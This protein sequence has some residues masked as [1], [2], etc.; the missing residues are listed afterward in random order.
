MSKDKA[1]VVIIDEPFD[2]P[3]VELVENNPANPVE[4][5]NTW[6]D[7]LFGPAAQRIQERLDAKMN[8][9]TP[10]PKASEF[11]KKLAAANEADSDDI[12]FPQVDEA[13]A[14]ASREKTIEEF[15]KFMDEANVERKMVVMPQPPHTAGL[16]LLERSEYL[17]S[18]AI[19]RMQQQLNMV[20]D[21][22][23]CHFVLLEVGVKAV[24][25]IPPSPYC[26]EMIV[27]NVHERVY[28][29][30]AAEMQAYL[31]KKREGE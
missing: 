6:D 12:K 25:V 13:A 20:G 9:A 15:E 29:G 8:A 18:C 23:G 5:M 16:I 26:V 10:G 21:L 11:F 22:V 2:M 14:K 17:T 31:D 3:V 4:V 27:D 7:T 28:F 1:T 19:E 24:P 30:S